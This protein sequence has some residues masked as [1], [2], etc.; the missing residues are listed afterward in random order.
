MAPSDVA[1]ARERA[2]VALL[3]DVVG[4]RLH[5]SPTLGSDPV[6]DAG[7]DVLRHTL[8]ADWDAAVH[9]VAALPVPDPDDDHGRWL[10]RA[11]TC[12]ALAGDPSSAGPGSWEGVLD[13]LPDPDAGLGRFAGHLLV[14]GALAHARLDLAGSLSDWI[15]PTLWSPLELDGAPHPFG[16]MAQLCRVRVLA[17]RGEL[18]AADQA[19]AAV[20]GSPGPDGPAGPVNGPVAAVLAATGCLVRGNQAAPSDVRRRVAVVDE[21]APEPV[22]HLTAGAQMLAAFGLIAIGD[23]VGAARRVLLAGGDETLSRLNVID[24]ALGLEM[25][26]VLALDAGDL[27]AAATWADRLLPLAASPIADS[28]VARAQS[29]WALAEGRAA[30]AVA[31]AERSVARAREVDRVIEYAEGSIVLNRARIA[32]RGGGA[33]RVADAVRALEEMVAEAERRGHRSARRSA[34]REL[35]PVGVRLRPLA[36][37]GWAGL[38]AREAE[39]ARHV[40]EGASN[41]EVARRMHVSEHTVRAHVSRVLAAF[42]VATRAGLPAVAGDAAAGRA[43]RPALTARQVEVATLVAQG[44]SN[45]AIGERLGISARTVEKH[46]GDILVRWDLSG[47]TAVAR[48]MA[49]DLG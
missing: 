36:G 37:S 22:D 45:R 30:D 35:R 27:D 41:R 31:W 12:W 17:F 2:L 3:D 28:T 4:S 34:A 13:D 42:G 25:L 16:V 9:S 29:R 48:E 5:D 44:L 19:L 11:V 18:A 24:R 21:H 6:W 20:T 43:D 7:L 10:H 47:R 49:R 38:S 33:G 26:L 39:V 8:A 14:E 1:V 23:V 40:V 32:Q 46:V 15:G